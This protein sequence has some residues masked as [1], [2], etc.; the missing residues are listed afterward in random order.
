MRARQDVGAQELRLWDSGYIST[1]A[2]KACLRETI[3]AFPPDDGAASYGTLRTIGQRVVLLPQAL[4]ERA[5]RAAKAERPRREVAAPCQPVPCRCSRAAEGAVPA[6]S[7]V[8]FHSELQRS[9]AMQPHCAC[10][11]LPASAGPTKQHKR[12]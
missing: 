3:S 5:G 4:D 10:A 7:L 9:A 8:P 1:V 6:L 12:A 2:D 11:R